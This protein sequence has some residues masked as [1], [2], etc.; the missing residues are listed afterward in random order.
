MRR[1]FW[2]LLEF[3]FWDLFSGSFPVSEK[4][5]SC[6]YFLKCFCKGEVECLI[7]IWERIGDLVSE[8]GMGGEAEISGA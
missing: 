5:A 8:F 6:V 2:G 4:K 3:N 7:G 1:W